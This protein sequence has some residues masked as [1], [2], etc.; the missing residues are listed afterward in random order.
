MHKL[1]AA[2]PYSER[3]N[4]VIREVEA[5]STLGRAGGDCSSLADW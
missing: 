4:S 5:A 2:V 3:Y 1:V